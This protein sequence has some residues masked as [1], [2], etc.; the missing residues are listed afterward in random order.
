MN[1]F[2]IIVGIV[3][4]IVF[5]FFLGLFIA[6]ESAFD[7][8]TVNTRKKSDSELIKDFFEFLKLVVKSLF[9]RRWFY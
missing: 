5:A 8:F 2:L 4:L 3:V 1:T 9:P 6:I 7:F